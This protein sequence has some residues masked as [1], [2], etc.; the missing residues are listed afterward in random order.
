MSAG[1]ISQ[2]VCFQFSYLFLSR[3]SPNSCSF[4]IMYCRR[5]L[6]PSNGRLVFKELLNPFNFS[7]TNSKLQMKVLLL[8]IKELSS[9]LVHLYVICAFCF[10]SYKGFSWS[11]LQL[12][13]RYQL[14]S[15]VA[16]IYIARYD[17]SFLLI[18]LI[19]MI[20]KLD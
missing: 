11:K 16:L 10:C 3:N 14:R 15:Q 4:G 8:K 18:L 1:Y 7:A 20:I 12:V 19:C 6:C 17:P 5:S 13:K 2:F 9:Q